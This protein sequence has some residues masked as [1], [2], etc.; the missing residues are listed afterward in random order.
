MM[1]QQYVC[2]VLF[3]SVWNIKTSSSLYYK[4]ADE[5][6]SHVQYIGE[7]SCSIESVLEWGMV[8]VSLGVERRDLE[9]LYVVNK[10]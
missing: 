2:F 5:G 8:R 10:D 6:P 1:Y 4:C 9:G 7:C 3:L